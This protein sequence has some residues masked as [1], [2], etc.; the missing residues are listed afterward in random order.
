M[1]KHEHPKYRQSAATGPVSELYPPTDGTVPPDCRRCLLVS[2][3]PGSSHGG[4]RLG[5]NRLLLSARPG[6]PLSTPPVRAAGEPPVHAPCPRGRG[7]PCPRPCPRGRPPHSERARSRPFTRPPGQCAERARPR[8]VKSPATLSGVVCVPLV[9]QRW[10]R[11]PRFRRPGRQPGR[12][13]YQVLVKEA[14]N[15]IQHEISLSSPVFLALES[16]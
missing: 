6:S 9:R 4:R 5:K 1:T 15:T 14:A 3:F 11:P 7:T 8:P 2:F 13:S 12:N 10:G 16:K